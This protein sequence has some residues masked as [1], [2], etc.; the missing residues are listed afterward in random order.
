MNK[1]LRVHQRKDLPGE[2]WLFKKKGACLFP[3]PLI[4]LFSD[5]IFTQHTALLQQ[6]LFL[7]LKVSRG[8]L[9]KAKLVRSPE[10]PK[11]L[12]SPQKR[13]TVAISW[14]KSEE[15]AVIQFIALFGEL[16]KGEWP[17]FGGQHVYWDKAAE[18]IQET[19][20]TTHRKTSKTY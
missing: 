2:R 16:K 20:K 1:K 10:S 8:I 7:S 12:I 15:I 13:K 4:C 6:Q 17:S 11:Q 14:E 9:R 19:A 18:F 3:W 5:F